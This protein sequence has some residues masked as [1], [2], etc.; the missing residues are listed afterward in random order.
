LENWRTTWIASYQG[1]STNDVRPEIRYGKRYGSIFY[2][3]LF[4]G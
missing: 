2:E 1:V 4:K 3:K